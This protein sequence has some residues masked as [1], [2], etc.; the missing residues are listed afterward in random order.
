MDKSNQTYEMATIFTSEIPDSE[1]QNHI[2]DVE[3]LIGTFGG[4]IH[5]TDV[6]GMRD[7]AYQIKK[8]DSGYYVFY[9]FEAPREA[10]HKIRDA[11]RLRED[12]LRQMI[13]VNENV[14]QMMKE[15]ENGTEE[16]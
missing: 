7:F 2:E 10:P 8:K 3:N 14:R 16:T 11:I 12:V 15:V 1:I 6:W 4:K 5:K 9:Y 13:L